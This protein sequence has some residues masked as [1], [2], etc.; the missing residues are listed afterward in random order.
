[1]IYSFSYPKT[2]LKAFKKGL[3]EL[4]GNNLRKMHRCANNKCSGN[5]S[6]SI[7]IHVMGSH[8]L[9]QAK[10]INFNFT[11][12]VPKTFLKIEHLCNFNFIVCTKNAHCALH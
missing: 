9:S 7:L 2:A 4:G 12:K 1:M 11:T 5:F 10:N 8:L 3:S 6:E